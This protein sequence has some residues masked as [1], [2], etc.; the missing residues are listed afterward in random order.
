MVLEAVCILLEEK[1]D[2]DGA[3][4]VMNDIGFFDRLKE[5]NK[6]TLAE[7]DNLLK[8]LRIITRKPEF[9]IEEIGRKSSACRGL[10]LWAKA[11]DNYAK[12]SKEVEPKKKKLAELSAKLEVK[13]K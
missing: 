12:I 11:M 1:A 8:K 2:W 6:E 7:K 9:D 4:K 13:N 3:K 10:A 5:F